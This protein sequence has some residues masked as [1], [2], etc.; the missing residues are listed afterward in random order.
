MNTAIGV[1]TAAF[2]IAALNPTPASADVN[3]LYRVAKEGDLPALRANILARGLHLAL[4]IA[5]DWGH[6]HLIRPLVVAG[7]NIDGNPQGG[8]PPLVPAAQLAQGT[9]DPLLGRESKEVKERTATDTHTVDVGAAVVERVSDVATAVGAAVGAAIEAVGVEVQRRGELSDSEQARLAL[10]LVGE[11]GVE[12][13]R[14]PAAR[15]AAHGEATDTDVVDLRP[16]VHAPKLAG[17]R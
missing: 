4:A 7:A 14:H 2:A 1:L 17:E 3:Q 11:S 5:A 8:R 13:P 15:L 6:P 9:A 10:A 12:G 16:G